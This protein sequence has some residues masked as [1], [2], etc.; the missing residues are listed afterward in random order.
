MEE[1][2][3]SVRCNTVSACISLSPASPSVNLET[4]IKGRTRVG[5]VSSR[6]EWRLFRGSGRI[7]NLENR[8]SSSRLLVFMRL[9]IFCVAMH[10]NVRRRG[11]IANWDGRESWKGKN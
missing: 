8:R 4:V 9:C 7:G 6:R 1:E 3:Q 11:S 5:F 10:L 2:G